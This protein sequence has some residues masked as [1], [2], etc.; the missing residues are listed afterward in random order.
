VT[1]IATATM[2][3]VDVIRGA[4]AAGCNLVVTFEPTFFAR[5]DQ[6]S[7]ANRATDPTFTGKR[8]LIERSNVA[9]WRLHDQWM[10]QRPASLTT[11]F[12]E[13]LQWQRYQT[14]A[15]T[16][17]RVVV[18]SMTLRDLVA[19]VQKQLGAKGL[20]VIGRPD[21]P[22]TRVV[23]SPGP[24]APAVTFTNLATADV[25]LA[26]EPREWEGVEYVQDA[27]AAGQAKGMVLVGRVLSENPGMRAMATWLTE[28]LPG[29]RVQ[30]LPVAD[31]YWRPAAS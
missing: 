8:D 2:A 11:A 21:L 15:T 9:I 17:E 23:L 20:R 19:H 31:P 14:A 27:I 7:P 30:S 1:G 4:S 12:S 16:P 3:T 25:I 10:A 24:S 22:V 28:L 26:G 6:S 13:A 18:P 29:M 5:A